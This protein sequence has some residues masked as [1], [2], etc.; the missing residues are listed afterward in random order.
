MCQWL[1]R[2]N[3]EAFVSKELGS[4]CES[5]LCGRFEVWPWCWHFSLTWRWHTSRHRHRYPWA[6]SSLSWRL[7]PPD[8]LQWSF[9]HSTGSLAFSPQCGT[10]HTPSLCTSTLCSFW[11][12]GCSGKSLW[13]NRRTFPLL[14]L[15]RRDKRSPQC[16]SWER[17]DRKLVLQ[18][19]GGIQ[20][21]AIK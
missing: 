11:S 5:Y 20:W 8:R 6:K 13:Q 4:P 7:L 17:R 15:G 3:K 19:G 12:A 21:R 1:N 18:R 16:V 14:L 9:C 2:V 10:T